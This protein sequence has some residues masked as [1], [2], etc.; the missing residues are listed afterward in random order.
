VS[1]QEATSPDASIHGKGPYK[2]GK[3]VRRRACRVKR[4]AQH[5]PRTEKSGQG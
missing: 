2:G 3:S 5:R 1:T 4:P